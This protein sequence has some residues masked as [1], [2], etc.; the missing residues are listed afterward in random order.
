MRVL[1]LIALATSAL[2]LAACEPAKAPETV[3][4]NAIA[5]GV[6][7]P[8]FEFERFNAVGEQCDQSMCASVAGQWLRFTD[9][10]A[11]DSLVQKQLL[12]L[13]DDKP[14]TLSVRDYLISFLDE[15]D[16]R[17]E[18]KLSSDIV[19]LTPRVMTLE[20][21]RYIY[22][23]GAHGSNYTQFL[24]YDLKTKKVLSLND[25]IVPGKEELFWNEAYASFN[26][27]LLEEVS[28]MPNYEEMWPFQQTENFALKNDRIILKYDEY[29]IGPYSFGEPELTVHFG[30]LKG[31]IRP[32]FL[33][34]QP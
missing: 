22:L 30:E 24:N 1:S 25:V 12:G 26:D 20:L 8:S 6:S 34:K 15:A 31:V 4:A 13:V 16:D 5:V 27:F 17:T 2:L 19:S 10:A 29:A 32:E 33:N 7:V 9:D 21:S 11:I 23:G 28:D 14:A 18:L 3:V